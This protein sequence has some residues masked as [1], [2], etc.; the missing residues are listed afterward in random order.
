MQE[1]RLTIHPFCY[2]SSIVCQAQMLQR[3]Q[4][5]TEMDHHGDLY[6]QEELLVCFC[7]IAEGFISS[8][9]KPS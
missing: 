6:P 5:H 2:S 8:S 9:I 1:I 3:T 4:E 7:A